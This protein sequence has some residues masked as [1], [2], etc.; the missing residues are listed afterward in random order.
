MQKF[1]EQELRDRMIRD[2]RIL[3]N[4]NTG[5]LS[6][7]HQ[8]YYETFCEAARYFGLLVESSDKKLDELLDE[9][10][11]ALMQSRAEFSESIAREVVLQAIKSGDFV[12]LIQGDKESAVYLPYQ[13]AT[14]LE[15]EAAMLRQQIADL[16]A[17]IDAERAV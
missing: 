12:R 15:S 17:H 3:P 4:A 9:A 1:T 6:P 16:H 5:C 10:A 2:G 13:R 7:N 11:T 8:R 14:Q